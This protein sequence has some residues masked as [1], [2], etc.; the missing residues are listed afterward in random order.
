MALSSTTTP[1]NRLMTVEATVFYIGSITTTLVMK[2]WSFYV[3]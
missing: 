3:M 2:T 1:T